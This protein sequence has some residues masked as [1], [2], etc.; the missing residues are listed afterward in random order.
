MSFLD[1]LLSSL[2]AD[3]PECGCGSAKP[4]LKVFGIMPISLHGPFMPA[5]NSYFELD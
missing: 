3:L 1:S 5:R 4:S 2:N